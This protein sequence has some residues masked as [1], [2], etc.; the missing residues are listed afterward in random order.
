MSAR[1]VPRAG[2]RAVVASEVSTASSPAGQRDLQGHV[3]ARGGRAHPHPDPHQLARASPSGA[4]PRPRTARSIAGRPAHGR[5]RCAAS[6]PARTGAPRCRRGIPAFAVAE[7]LQR[8]R[9]P[10][11]GQLA[12]WG[13]TV[14][15]TSM[16]RPWNLASATWLPPRSTRAT[17]FGASFSRA[18]TTSVSAI[19]AKADSWVVRYRPS[20]PRALH[21]VAGHLPDVGVVGS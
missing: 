20:V 8:R 2:S 11:R 18:R 9:L 16:L 12:P 13:C 19:S 15:R 10:Q 14:R 7:E 4:G 5:A 17:K 3:G 21:Q 6:P 1:L